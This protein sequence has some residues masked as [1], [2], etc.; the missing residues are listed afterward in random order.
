MKYLLVLFFIY[1]CKP[2]SEDLKLQPKSIW[3]SY[4]NMGSDMTYGRT[5]SVCLCGYESYLST[6]GTSP[7]TEAPIM[8]QTVY[9][10][11][12]PTYAY[13]NWRN[14]NGKTVPTCT[15]LRP[16]VYMFVGNVYMRGYRSCDNTTQNVDLYDTVKITILKSKK[17]VKFG[18]NN[19]DI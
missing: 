7:D 4:V 18:N 1:G 12:G 17:T 11:L 15:N 8:G 10:I 16:G 5:D 3:P 19:N 13:I 2:A 14:I 6:C 9:Q